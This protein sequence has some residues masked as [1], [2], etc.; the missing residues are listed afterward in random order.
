M[1]SYLTANG[2]VA[3][4]SAIAFGA[5]ETVAIAF[6][7]ALA[8]CRVRGLLANVAGIAVDSVVFVWLAF[9]T[10]AFV[11]GQLVGKACGLLIAPL[12]IS[13]CRCL[14]DPRRAGAGPV[15]F[16]LGTHHPHW[17]RH[18]TV[19]LF[20][21][22]RTLRRYRTLPVATCP[23]ALDSG[24]FTELS[25]HGSWAHGPSPRA[26]ADRVRR[27]RD[28]IG[29]QIGNLAWA[30][31]QDWMCEPF[32]TAITGL[33]VAEHQ[34]RTVQNYL[35]LTTIAPDLPFIPVLQGFA[36]PDYGACVRRYQDAGVDLTTCPVVGVGSVCRRQGTA[37]AAEVIATIR[38]A[39]PGVRLHGFGVKSTGLRRYGHELSSS[40]SLAWSMA[41]S[42]RHRYRAAIGMPVARTVPGTRCA[43]A[44]TCSPPCLPI[45]P[46]PRSPSGPS[47]EFRLSAHRSS[48]RG[49]RCM[50]PRR[51]DTHCGEWTR[52]PVFLF[53]S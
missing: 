4:S 49:R 46:A 44:T 5:S 6:Y 12:L 1:L 51:C 7:G 27:Y 8:Q 23:W 15:R 25:T 48:A 26:Y 52:G 45:P 24:G 9:A 42:E 31:P 34:R 21:S 41:A 37:E 40:D 3:T 33:S 17:L 35:T 11:P 38:D 18:L 28:Q 2:H 14:P 43:G 36:P 19:P 53:H 47:R 50:V 13:C 39:V 32:I 29:N 20:V 30:A 10:L 22:D 16:F